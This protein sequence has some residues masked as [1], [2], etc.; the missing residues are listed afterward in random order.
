MKYALQMSICF[1]LHCRSQ[2]KNEKGE[3][4]EPQP[5]LFESVNLGLVTN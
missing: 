1:R 5:N 4:V 3:K 2:K